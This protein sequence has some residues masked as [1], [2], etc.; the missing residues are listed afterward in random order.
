MSVIDNFKPNKRPHPRREPQIEPPA[1]APRLDPVDMDELADSI[2]ASDEYAP[3]A[4]RVDHMESVAVRA[5]QKFAELPTDEID[6][7]IEAAEAEYSELKAEAQRIKET[8][9][10]GVE[11]LS[12]RL[13]RFMSGV[14]LSTEAFQHLREQCLALDQPTKPPP[15]P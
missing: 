11:Q 13:K 5:I 9:H 6:R 15:K 1:P 12:A 8:Y 4:R 3:P 14:K 7:V 2:R 10:D